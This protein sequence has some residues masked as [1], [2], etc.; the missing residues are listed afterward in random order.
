ML[1]T[2]SHALGIVVLCWLVSAQAAD[3]ETRLVRLEGR[4]GIEQQLLLVSPPDPVAIAVLFAGYGGNID[5]QDGPDGPTTRSHNFLVRSRDLFAGQDLMVAVVDAPSDKHYVEGMLYGFR[6][7]DRH[8][9]DITAVIRWLK[10]QANL[11]VWLVGTSRGTESAT[12]LA[13]KLPGLVHGLV[14]SSPM[15]EPNDMGTTLPAMALERIRQPVQIV[16]NLDDNC[17]VTPSYGAE[18]I[19]KGLTA[20]SAVQ[21]ERLSGSP[22]THSDPCGANSAHGFL[23]IEQQVVDRIVAFIK[24]H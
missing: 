18:K 14:L 1:R 21:V 17:R 13:I 22:G 7:S 6:T 23:G 10:R 15:T 9:T 19:R 11:P 3:I 5:L 8:V 4:P 2:L 12:H 16:V 20:A 24:S